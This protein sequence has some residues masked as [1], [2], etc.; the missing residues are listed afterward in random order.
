ML[1][2]TFWDCQFIIYSKMDLFKKDE[3]ALS[4][5]EVDNSLYQESLL[6]IILSDSKSH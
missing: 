6:Q 3:K 4:N 1:N 5:I 2:K